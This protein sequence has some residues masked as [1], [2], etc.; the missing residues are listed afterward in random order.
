MNFNEMMTQMQ[1]QMANPLEIKSKIEHEKLPMDAGAHDFFEVNMRFLDPLSTYEK[2]GE[3]H[4]LCSEL[5]D[6]FVKYLEKENKISEPG[7]SIH[8]DWKKA[9]L[10]FCSRSKKTFPNEN[11]KNI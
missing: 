11:D 8:L 4:A 1:M 7:L 5:F 9:S 10:R 3:I 6:C 2:I